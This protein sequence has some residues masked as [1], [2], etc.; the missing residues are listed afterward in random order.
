MGSERLGCG[1][2]LSIGASFIGSC[3]DGFLAPITKSNGDEAGGHQGK[4]NEERVPA[5]PGTEYI[6]EGAAIMSG[7]EV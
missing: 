4:Q 2:P 1:A 3:D 6:I 5:P 7:L